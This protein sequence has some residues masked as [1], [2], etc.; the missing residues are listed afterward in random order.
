MNVY[1][2]LIALRRHKVS[3]ILIV[4]QIALTLAI[5]ANAFF[6]IG[7]TIEHMTRPSGL[8]ED[9][10]IVILQKWPGL[11][12]V[13]GDALTEKIDALQRTDLETIRNLSDVQDVAASSQENAAGEISLDADRK[14]KFARA[15]YFYGDEHLRPTLGLHLIAGRDFFAN[16]IRHGEA[17]PGS[18]VVIVSKTLADQ[19]FPH[20]NALG[21][22]V[23]QDGK[24]AA[25]V[26]IVE[27]LQTSMGEDTNWEFNS[28]MEPLREDVLWTAYA[29]RAR[30]GR[31]TEAIGEIH[32]ALFAVKPMRHMPEPWAGI[33]S[34]SELRARS[35]REERGIALL[36]GVICLI[37]LSVTAA[38]IVGLTSFWVGQRHRQIGVRRALGARKID[39]LLYFQIEN[40]LIV[41]SGAVIGALCALGL[42]TWLM[43]HYE[44][45]HLPLFYVATGVLAML[46]LGQIAVL[47]PARRASNVPPV[48]ATR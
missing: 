10:L 1:P 40:L 28:V 16:E 47:T 19:L 12:G 33:H 23:Y 34:F 14:G 13:D 24:A 30:P 36:M 8:Q 4:L 41:G 39:I 9:G 15:G 20:G 44:M 42:N 3:V 17:L 22:T 18:S 29:A 2:I 45:L 7:H 32:K 35:F 38:G 48:V 46:V 11:S 21:Q 6:I 43:K 27:R 26:G 25:I 31:T 5:V 37:L